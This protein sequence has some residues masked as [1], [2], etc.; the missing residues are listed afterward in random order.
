MV[1]YQIVE[2][3]KIHAVD[4]SEYPGSTHQLE[5]GSLSHY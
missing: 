4:G 5:V 2:I 3:R 1:I